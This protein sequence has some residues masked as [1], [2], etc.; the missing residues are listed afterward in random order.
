MLT[1]PVVKITSSSRLRAPLRARHFA[2][3]SAGARIRPF[4]DASRLPRHPREAR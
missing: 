1:R 2:S 4:K 3:S